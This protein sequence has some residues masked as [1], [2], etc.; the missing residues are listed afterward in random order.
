MKNEETCNE[1]W[2]E[3]FDLVALNQNE[4]QKGK[5]KSVEK[6]DLFLVKFL[7]GTFLKL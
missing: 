2:R 3:L 7:S 1:D 6:E 5:K 4:N